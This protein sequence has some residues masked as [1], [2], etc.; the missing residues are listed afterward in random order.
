MCGPNVCA[1]PVRQSEW[2]AWVW[3]QECELYCP[4][5][6]TEGLLWWWVSDAP[7]RGALLHNSLTISQGS[8]TKVEVKSDSPPVSLNQPLTTHLFHPLYLLSPPPPPPSLPS[9][10]PSR[11]PQSFVTSAAL[12]D[13]GCS[14]KWLFLVLVFACWRREVRGLGWG[15]GEVGV[16]MWAAATHLSIGLGCC[17][18]FWW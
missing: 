6:M 10:E 2:P 1:C 15:W 14:Q 11:A 16:E 3:T 5:T 17:G 18:L 8:C 12:T 7:G 9:F 4:H 13:C